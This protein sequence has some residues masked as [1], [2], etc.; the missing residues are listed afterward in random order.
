MPCCCRPECQGGQE[1]AHTEVQLEGVRGRSWRNHE[2]ETRLGG[3]G[4]PLKQKALELLCLCSPL[5]AYAPLPPIFLYSTEALCPPCSG[6]FLG[7]E[8]DLS[9]RKQEETGPKRAVT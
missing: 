1:A 7:S 9:L 8:T 2:G 6:Q 5:P 4:R 3:E